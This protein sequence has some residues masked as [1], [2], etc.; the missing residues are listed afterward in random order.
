MA[1]PWPIPHSR[2]MTERI[3]HI[4][5]IGRRGEG[6]AHVDGR[7]VF[8]AG[9]LP[10]EDVQVDAEG[11]RPSLLAVISPAADRTEPFC[12]HFG[13]CG[14]C[15]LQHWSEEPYRQWKMSLVERA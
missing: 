6:I 15:Q 1:L 11:E 3:L 8:V 10:G 9:T 5:G 2:A 7:P 12:R 14:G 4:D 13:R